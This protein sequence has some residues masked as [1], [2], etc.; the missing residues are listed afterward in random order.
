[1]KSTA[2]QCHH[3]Q[4][5]SWVVEG[6][7]ELMNI[8]GSFQSS[9]L[10]TEPYKLFCC[11]D[12][13]D[14]EESALLPLGQTPHPL[15]LSSKEPMGHHADAG[16]RWSGCTCPGVA[17]YPS[18]AGLSQCCLYLGPAS[19]VG[20]VPDPMHTAQIMGEGSQGS[21][22][23]EGGLLISS[24]LVGLSPTPSPTPI[25]YSCVLPDPAVFLH[26]SS[27]RELQL[28][29]IP[30]KAERCGVS[31]TPGAVTF[32]ASTLPRGQDLSLRPPPILRL[33]QARWSRRR[34][35]AP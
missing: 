22:G 8:W 2:E 19:T 12:W 5:G 16:I 6:P 3:P 17:S 32:N 1:M 11:Q 34:R 7:W 30:A 9:H 18:P 31:E 15:L 14:V 24:P 23:A 13:K 33:A 26:H 20:A 4:E 25:L 27:F 21:P 10:K 35:R 29:P 28:A